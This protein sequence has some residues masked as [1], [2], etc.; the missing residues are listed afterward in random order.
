M[1]WFWGFSEARRE[2]V[3]G[4]P[5]CA[6][7]PQ[8]G[9]QGKS[10]QNL[11]GWSLATGRAQQR[12]RITPQPC[13][14]ADGEGNPASPGC[15]R[16][17]RRC[18]KRPNCPVL[19]YVDI[20]FL[21]KAGCPSSKTTLPGRRKVHRGWERL[22]LSPVIAAL[23][24][25]S[26]SSFVSVR[27]NIRKRLS[28]RKHVYSSTCWTLSVSSQENNYG[29]LIYFFWWQIIILTIFSH[30]EGS[31]TFPSVPLFT[32]SESGVETLMETQFS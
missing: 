6:Q 12:M 11:L 23:Q 4:S 18:V 26:K 32:Q 14:T 25:A 21:I 30:F 1:W 24:C 19:I 28:A 5:E 20:C 27:G 8:T 22:G 29:K 13:V 2:R 10:L 3:L 15:S 9:G 7:L 16:R 17:L 31:V